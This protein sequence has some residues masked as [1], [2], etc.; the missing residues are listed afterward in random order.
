MTASQLDN[1]PRDN[2]V[3]KHVVLDVTPEVLELIA[4]ALINDEHAIAFSAFTP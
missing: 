1:N 2:L 3:F 4:Q